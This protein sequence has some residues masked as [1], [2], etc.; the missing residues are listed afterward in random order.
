MGSDDRDNAARAEDETF[1]I[2]LLDGIRCFLLYLSRI[3]VDQRVLP[4]TPA[5]HSRK[6]LLCFCK[7]GKSFTVVPVDDGELE[8]IQQREVNVMPM[9]VQEI[10]P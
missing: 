4:H 9:Q 7:G 5:H 2:C 1:S 3:L 8:R 6:L 10:A